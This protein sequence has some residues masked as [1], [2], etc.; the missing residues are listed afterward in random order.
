L[1]QPQLLPLLKITIE[2]IKNK[3][4]S[5]GQSINSNIILNKIEVEPLDLLE[6]NIPKSKPKKSRPKGTKNKQYLPPKPSKKR[7]TRTKA[8]Q[9]RQFVQET[10]FISYNSKELVLEYLI[11]F[12]ISTKIKKDPKTIKEVLLR[13]DT[14]K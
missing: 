9:T 14:K 5:D 8:K 12:Y 1:L 2:K 4:F 6:I 3:Y 7:L 11:A 13:L 10:Y